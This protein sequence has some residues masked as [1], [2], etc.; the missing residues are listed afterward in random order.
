MLAIII[1]YAYI[2]TIVYYAILFAIGLQFR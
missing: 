2:F 1:Q